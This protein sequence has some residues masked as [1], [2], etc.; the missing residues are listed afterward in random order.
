MELLRCLN[1]TQYDEAVKEAAGH[2][3]TVALKEA[4]KSN[5]MVLEWEAKVEEGREHQAFAEAFWAVVWVCPPEALGTFMYPLQ[6]LT[7]DVL[8]AALM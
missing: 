3:S 2:P 1:D 5:I 8:L 6:L 7:S 4:Y